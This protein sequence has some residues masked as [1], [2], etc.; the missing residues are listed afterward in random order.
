MVSQDAHTQ[1]SLTNPS[2]S[3]SSASAAPLSWNAWCV[4]LLFTSTLF[5]VNLGQARTITAHEGFVVQIARNILASGDWLVPRMFGTT[6]LERPPLNYWFVAALG[7]FTGIDAFTARLPSVLFGVLGVVLLTSWATNWFGARFG[8]LLGFMQATTVYTLTYARLAESDIFLWTVVLACLRIFADRVVRPTPKRWYSNQWVFFFLLGT[9]QLLKGPLFG[10][11]MV[12][13]PCLGYVLWQRNKRG[14]C[15]LC[16]W[17]GWVLTTCI[18]LAWPVAILASHPDAMNVWWVHTFGRLDNHTAIN[19]KP[20]WY[21]ATTM[22]WQMLPWT[23]L[24]WFGMPASWKRWRRQS[25]SDAFLWIWFILPFLILSLISGKHHHYLIYAL[26]ACSFW[27]CEGLL[28][29][30]EKTWLRSV[31]FWGTVLTGCVVA[32]VGF[33]LLTPSEQLAKWWWEVSCFS[34]LVVVTLLLLAWA[35]RKQKIRVAE[36][37]L[38]AALWLGIGLAHSVLLHKTDLYRQDTLLLQRLNARATP[39]THV[40]IYGMYPQRELAYLQIPSVVVATP[41]NINDCVAKRP[42]AW[43]LTYHNCEAKL[44][45]FGPLEKLDQTPKPRRASEGPASHMVV[46]R[47][48]RSW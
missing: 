7:S 9:T 21:Y 17:P 14:L 16:Y 35:N 31:L 48:E 23:V 3:T 28:I 30:E 25:P 34:L 15:W 39:K 24:L 10:A 6:Y 45:Q 22:P 1:T 11:A 43:I 37:V 40:I 29:L 27:V 13:L 20:L 5:L 36:V 2:N 38:F 42:D 4:L 8:L 26:P 46:Y 41:K 47:L 33:L 19:P 44:R 18:A 12:L 32:C